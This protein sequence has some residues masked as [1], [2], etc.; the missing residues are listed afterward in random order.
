MWRKCIDSNF[1]T[2][3]CYPK[4]TPFE[5]IGAELKQKY[6]N[7]MRVWFFNGKLYEQIGSQFKAI[8]SE[9][10]R[11]VYLDPSPDSCVRNDTLGTPGMLGRTCR[12]SNVTKSDCE[13]F[14]A[15]CSSCK[16]RYE[17]KEYFEQYKCNCKFIWCCYVECQTCTKK[18]SVTTCFANREQ[19]EY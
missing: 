16:F 3:T 2:Q 5:M 19:S 9:D 1:D 11:L 12:S 6:H 4:L 8:S 7:A 18:Y 15:L 14:K 13:S 10:N 17:T